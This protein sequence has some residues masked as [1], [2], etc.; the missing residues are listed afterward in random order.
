MMMIVVIVDVQI[1]VPVYLPDVVHCDE[2]IPFSPYH[3]NSSLLG[4]SWYVR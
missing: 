3:E 1:E 2:V 4:L